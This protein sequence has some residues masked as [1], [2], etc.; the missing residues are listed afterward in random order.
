[1]S[2]RKAAAA[3]ATCA[4]TNASSLALLFTADCRA[5]KQSVQLTERAQL[6]WVNCS[7]ETQYDHMT[8][9]ST[10]SSWHAYIV[11]VKC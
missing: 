8:L 10:G 11:T 4:V 2:G 6:H 3:R 7:S 1:M 9:Q 5:G